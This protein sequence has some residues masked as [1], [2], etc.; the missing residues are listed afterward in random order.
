MINA[1]YVKATGPFLWKNSRFPS[2]K[3]YADITQLK[4]IDSRIYEFYLQS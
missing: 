1:E 3:N 2:Y 4:Y